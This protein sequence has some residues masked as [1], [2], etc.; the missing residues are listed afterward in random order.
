M[1]AIVSP[2]AGWITPLE[3]VPDPVFA[4]RMLGDGIAIDPVEGRVLAPAAAVVSSVH[5]AGHAITL[6]LDTGPVLLIHIG[7]DTVAL[8]GDG[9]TPTV[10]DGDHV[11]QGQTLIEFDLDLLARRARSLVTPVIVTNG[12][13]FCVAVSA[14]EGRID[15]GEPLLTLE[16]VA[17]AAIAQP[18]MHATASRSLRLLL[19]HGLHARPAA[20]I[21][22]LAGEFDA[23]VEIVA[24][25]GRTASARSP[26]TILGLGL[27]HGGNVTIRGEG[28][29]ADKAVAAIA[30]LLDSGMGELLP[31]AERHGAAAAPEPPQL[32]HELRGISAVAGMAIGAAWQVKQQEIA[33][34]E[35]ASDPQAEREAL[36]AARARVEGELKAEAE[37]DDPGAAVA[38]A[39]LAMIGD[40]AMEEA[41][42]RLIAEG[43][44]AAF[45]WRDAVRQFA[46]PLRASGD[47]RF[48]DRFDDLMD[49]ERRI[50]ADLVGAHVESARPPKGAILLAE[51][52]YPSQLKKFAEL[53]I[54]GIATAAGGATSHAAIIAAGLGLPMVVGLGSALLRVEDG[55]P[56]VLRG[57]TLVVASDASTLA[58]A[59]EEAEQRERI[60]EA[61]RARADELAITADGQRIEVFANLGSVADAT[62][63]VAQGAEGCG[64]LR[65]EFLFLDRVAPPDEAEQCHA[66]QQIADALGERP[67]IVR[68]LDIGA[69]KPAPWLP[70]EPEDNPALGLRGI[71]LQLA[72]TGLL[73]TQLRALLGVRTAGPLRIM[74]PMVSAVGELRDAKAILQSLAV[75]MNVSA[76]EL[77]IMVET[78]AAA[79]LAAILAEQAAF[80]S[81]GTN[82]LSQ[83]A[84][85]RDRTNPAVA[86]GL[87]G[88]DPAVLRL[89]DET[90]RGA[91]SRGRVTGVCGGLAAMAEAV[92]ILVGLGITELSV[93]A[94]SVAE[95][96]AVVRA[97]DVARCRTLATEAL[98]A[99]DAGTVRALAGLFLEQTA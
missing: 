43:K 56:L 46:A 44:S 26:V 11:A 47:R 30:E 61:A 38:A 23:Q 91:G 22:N 71:R 59:R 81:I 15:T 13:A 25:D 72:Q 6:K 2:L 29:Q 58:R 33:V 20:R 21:A 78:P 4:E 35:E 54:A 79:L 9:F 97:L 75:E 7:L 32:P 41:A 31:L 50:L 45:A 66:Y 53:G 52:L 90:I 24:D 42:Q 5:P 16:A 99:P 37:G 70:L 18:V 3:N 68:T 1:I 83:Y 62:L 28:P 14:G 86:A 27:R 64:L 10:R 49:L 92:P 84:L 48:A 88:L 67:L 51:T 76:P 94:G 12:D 8:D 69:D 34:P 87:D 82:D 93:P 55:T 57:D 19:A 74:L 77:G 63:A 40:P 65:T 60:H 96:K 39:H 73:Q 95:I 89:I 17:Q 85:A 98:S 80:F 36:A